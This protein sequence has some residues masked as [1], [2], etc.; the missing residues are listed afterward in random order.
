[1]YKTEVIAA[2]RH[3]ISNRVS[4]LASTV[5]GCFYCL[6]TFAPGEIRE[7]LDEGGEEMATA[8]CP[9]C[10]IDSLLGDKSGFDISESFLKAMHAHWF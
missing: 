7:W 6:N 9:V 10:G 3:S 8:I 1:M 4:I 5:C 2:H